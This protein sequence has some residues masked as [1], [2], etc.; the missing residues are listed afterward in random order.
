[1]EIGLKVG[2]LE[3]ETGGLRGVATLPGVAALAAALVQE[4]RAPPERRTWRGRVAG[5]VPYDLRPPTP[6]RL[7]AALWHPASPELL[8]PTAVGVGGSVNLAA[9]AGRLGL[10]ERAGAAPPGFTSEPEPAH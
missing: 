6:E 8:A 2:G 3:L 1:V 5:F 7:R 4:L 9:L 10:R